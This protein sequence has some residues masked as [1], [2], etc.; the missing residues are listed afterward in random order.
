MGF[1]ELGQEFFPDSQT[2]FQ[3]TRWDFYTRKCE[4]TKKGAKLVNFHKAKAIT[5]SQCILMMHWLMYSNFSLLLKSVSV[6]KKKTKTQNSESISV[7]IFWLPPSFVLPLCPK[8]L[9]LPLTLF[10]QVFSQISCPVSSLQG[11]LVEKRQTWRQR[12]LGLNTSLVSCQVCQVGQI[13]HLWHAGFSRSTTLPLVSTSP[14][15]AWVHMY[16]LTHSP[17]NIF[18]SLPRFSVCRMWLPEQ[19]TSKVSGRQTEQR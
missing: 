6:K 10:I 1:L 7:C 11:G 16:S 12:G 18:E 8:P 19:V 5:L 4:E 2:N 13:T 17:S 3:S 14:F 15:L 9:I